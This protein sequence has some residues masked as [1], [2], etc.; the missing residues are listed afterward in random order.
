MEQEEVFEIL[1]S[2]GFKRNEIIIYLDLIRFGRSSPM[3]IA[4]RT[5]FHKSNTYEILEKLKQKGIV[6]ETIINEKKY[7]YPIDPEDIFDYLKQKQKELEDIIPELK[8]VQETKIEE[9]RVSL[10]EGLNSAKNII[11]RMLDH[12]EGIS[13]YAIPKEIK[14]YLGVFLDEFHRQRIKRKIPL[15]I[16]YESKAMS[17]IKKLN[18]MDFTTARYLPIKKDH[19]STFI[20]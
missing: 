17:Q 13:A 20:K 11:S 14:D 10:S 2:I 7:Y 3:D 9:S 1:E 19:I 4:K 16:I 8:K 6:D 15:R 18:E 5:G 12:K